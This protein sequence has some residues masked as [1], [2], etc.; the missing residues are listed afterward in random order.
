M[1]SRIGSAAPEGT[2]RDSPDHGFGRHGSCAL[3]GSRGRPGCPVRRAG[4]SAYDLARSQVNVESQ[5]AVASM[6]AHVSGGHETPIQPSDL[7]KWCDFSRNS[8]DSHPRIVAWTLR[9]FV[10]QTAGLFAQPR[11]R[12]P[13]FIWCWPKRSKWFFSRRNT[14]MLGHQNGGMLWVRRWEFF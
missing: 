5:P 9:L 3:I 14:S 8:T 10:S 6:T 4:I 11:F 12:E 7:H 13:I 1:R 2:T